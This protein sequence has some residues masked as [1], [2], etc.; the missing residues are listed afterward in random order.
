MNHLQE[1][2]KAKGLTQ[3]QLARIAEIN[4]TTIQKMES[5]VTDIEKIRL[6]N[7]LKLAR[8]LGTTAEDLAQPTK[9]SAR[10]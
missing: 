9:K 8:A 3:E 5:G 4:L 6:G 7:A 1:L 10:Q 2:R